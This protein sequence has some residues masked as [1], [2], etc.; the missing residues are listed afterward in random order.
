MLR[1]S[2]ASRT[3][4]W[5]VALFALAVLAPASASASASGCAGYTGSVTQSCV[6][7]V[8]TGTYVTSVSGGVKLAARATFRGSVKVWGSGFSYSS[9]QRTT[10]NESW[11]ARTFWTSTWTLNRNLTNGSRVCAQAVWYDGSAEDTA[12]VT[13]KR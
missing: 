5:V 6:K 9:G 11:I 10:W 4:A 7:V 8:G 2:I 3:A 12:C 13:I 1:S